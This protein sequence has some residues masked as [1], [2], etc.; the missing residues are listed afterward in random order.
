MDFVNNGIIYFCC[1]FNFDF[2]DTCL[3]VISSVNLSVY[4]FK[5]F[6]NYAYFTKVSIKI[7]FFPEC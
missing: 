7:I 5:K 3:V 1:I 2:F 6:A 4:V